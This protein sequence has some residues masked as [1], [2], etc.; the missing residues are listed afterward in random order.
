MPYSYHQWKE[1]VKQKYSPYSIEQLEEFTRYLELG[2]VNNN[3]T[4]ESGNIFYAAIMSCSIAFIL[5]KVD[6]FQIQ[7]I[8]FITVL[9][10]IILMLC[11]IIYIIYST[12]FPIFNDNLER[13]LYKDYQKIIEQI[14]IEKEGT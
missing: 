11:F 12:V 5:E 6:D 3:A 10:F 1:S 14:I 7:G 4:K 13:N 8:E 9:F 2:I